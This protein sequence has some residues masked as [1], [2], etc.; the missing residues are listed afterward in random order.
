MSH[1][2]TQVKRVADIDILKVEDEV[3]D[4]YVLQTTDRNKLYFYKSYN[5]S[6][7]FEVGMCLYKL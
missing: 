7:V 2:L 5:K 4:I 3:F 6:N 1:L